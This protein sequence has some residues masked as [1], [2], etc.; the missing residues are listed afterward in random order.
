MITPAPS[1]PVTINGNA[2]SGFSPYSADIIF[3]VKI[4]SVTAG[5]SVEPYIP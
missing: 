2:A 5:G 4:P 1:M 3:T